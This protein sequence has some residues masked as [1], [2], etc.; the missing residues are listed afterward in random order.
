M[1]DWGSLENCCACKRTVG[2]NPTLSAIYLLILT[3][4][5]NAPSLPGMG[6]CGGAFVRAAIGGLIPE[7]ALQLAT[8]SIGDGTAIL[9]RPLQRTLRGGLQLLRERG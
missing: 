4:S 9:D 8:D 5:N 1:A 2:S 3:V 7:Q 6:K